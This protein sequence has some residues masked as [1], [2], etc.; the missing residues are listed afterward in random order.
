MPKRNYENDYVSITTA[1]G[2]LNKPGLMMWM[3]FNTAKF[4]DAESKRGKE[5]GLLLHEAFQK[6]IE[7]QEVKVKTAYPDEVTNALQSFM[8]F[9]KEHPEIKLE[10]SEIQMVSDTYKLNGTLDCLG[11]IG[12]E[13]VI[14]DWKNSKVGKKDSPVIYPEYLWQTAGYSMM[15]EDIFK[16][17]VNS[18]YV[19]VLAKDAVS[20]SI[21]K[22]DRNEIVS[23]FENVVL[24]CVQIYYHK[25]KK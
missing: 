13:L 14:M 22:I 23:H 16:I 20:Y 25:R 24:P 5:V 7:L 2:V 12:D 3:K 15:Y 19:V 21:Q 4:C 6:H 8:L 17:Q 18:A 11:K 9:K 10:K 1:L